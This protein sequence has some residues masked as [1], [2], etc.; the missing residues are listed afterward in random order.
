M[1]PRSVQLAR[2]FGRQAF[3]DDPANYDVARPDYPDWVFET[4]RERCGLGPGCATFEVGAGTGKATRPLL[5][6]GR[7]SARRHRAG[8]PAG[9][10]PAL[11]RRLAGAAGA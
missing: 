9:G 8:R 6:A 10:V 3:G 1:S 4:L 11:E 5:A 7:R 2:S